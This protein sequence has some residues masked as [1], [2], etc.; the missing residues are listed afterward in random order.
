MRVALRL[1]AAIAATATG[2]IAAPAAG[3][4]DLTVRS[5]DGT[6]ISAV[7]TPA[8]GLQPGQR[9]PVMLMTHGFA[10]TRETVEAGAPAFGQVG[11][12]TFRAHGYSTLTWDSRGFGRSGGE[13]ALDSPDVDGRD[14][15]ALIDALARRSDVQL[16]APGD[17]RVGMHGAS[18][19][20]GIE[21]ATAVRDRRV[22]AIAPAISWVDLNDA[23]ARDGRV[24]LGWG[25]GLVG[26][27]EATGLAFGLLAPQ[28]PELG[29]FPP[30]MLTDAL[31]SGAS[32]Y[33][34]P[35]FADTLQRASTADRIAEVRAP[36]L[37]LQGTADTIFTP[38]QAVKMRALLRPAGVPV[39]MVWF[40]GGHG[41]CLTGDPFAS[42]IDDIVLRWM[43]RWLKGDARV[44]TGPLFE[45]AS[46]DGV[47]RHADD[48]PLAA[49]DPIIARGSGA[50]TLTPL[51]TS[52]LG[53]AAT[54]ALAGISIP[55]P[56]PATPTDVVGDPQ[57]NLRYTGGG[58]TP[59]H[60]FAQIVDDRRGLVVGNQATPVPLV[61]DGSTH[62]VDR[63]LEGVAMRAGPG[64]RYRLQLIPD[65]TVYGAG[66]VSGA[67]RVIRATL[68]L[69][70]GDAAATRPPPP[71]VA[72]SCRSR[73][74]VVVALG[75]SRHIRR[76]TVTVDG[77]RVAFGRA[78]GNRVRL[79]LAARTAGRTA[80]VRISARLRG[81]ATLRV[82]R[83]YR[84]CAGAPA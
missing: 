23:L 11:A 65:T 8:D 69:P 9:A 58:G 38:S 21:W 42:R 52:G 51:A 28:G 83:R 1:L 71:P 39:K 68:S 3:A 35:S 15:S 76:V 31:A 41:I 53:V 59:A 55:I 80:T 5:F 32:G 18:Y 36:S 79:T 4:E 70:A 67:V 44:D 13:I 74:T 81:G 61:L 45:W 43:D 10:L 46:D 72:A 27:G 82:V 24:K 30:A 40:C 62:E 49:A 34:T 19:G 73:R 29:A 56:S 84:L 54:P 2:L 33:A 47:A 25:A 22:D 7:F 66:R 60:L 63:P 14:V 57:L 6:A 64:S 12:G 20:G 78:S 77:R 50:L 17:P 75:R 48:F 37:I 26:A 16:D